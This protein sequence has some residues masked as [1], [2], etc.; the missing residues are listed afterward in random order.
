MRLARAAGWPEAAD[1][2]SF[3]ALLLKDAGCAANAAH[4][5]ALFGTDD[6]EAKRDLKWRNWTR[7]ADAARYALHN[8]LPGAP[9]PRRLARL[10]ALALGG[11]RA[12]RQMVEVRCRRG[13]DVLRQLGWVEVAPEAVLH[14]DEHWDGSGLPDGRM[15]QAIPRASRLALLAQQ[16]EIAH[17]RGGSAAALA[18]ARRLRGR[19]FDPELCDV[20]AHLGAEPAF[21]AELSAAGDPSDLAELDPRPTLVEIGGGHHIDVVA[22]TFAQVV[23]EKSAWTARHSTRTAAYAA[24]LARALGLDAR[25]VGRVET[26]AFYHDLGKLGVSNLVL[27]KPGPLDPVERRAIERHVGLT[28]DILAPLDGVLPVGRIAAAHHERLDGSGYDQALRAN[29]VP[30][31]AMIVA[32]ADVFDALTAARP[33]RQALTP[34]EAVAILARDAG[35]RLP[36]AVVGAVRA[37]L[38]AGR[39]QVRGEDGPADARTAAPVG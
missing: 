3:Y 28:R 21:W 37:E 26:A 33:Y 19:W 39:L 8:V 12:Q 24:V 7:Y 36:A 35:S 5:S 4:V 2:R 18:M 34:D 23:D 16:V 9:T 31:E 15:G 32:A 11:K 13:A 17:A 1:D 6:I 14:L 10:A 29:A 20:L 30:A 22:R 27:D 38:G 25:A